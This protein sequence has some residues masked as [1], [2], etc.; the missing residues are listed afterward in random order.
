M[1]SGTIVQNQRTQQFRR[2]IANVY[3]ACDLSLAV[4]AQGNSML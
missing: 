2:E 1:Q 4:C 3:Q